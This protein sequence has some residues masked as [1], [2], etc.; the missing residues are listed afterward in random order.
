MIH[1][2]FAI[3]LFI[4]PVNTYLCFS[5]TVE[6]HVHEREQLWFG[7]FNQ[8]RI[9]NKF[10]IWFDVHYRQT[11]NFIDR[12]FQFVVR[13]GV[14]YFL[15]DNLRLQAGYAFFEHF[16]AKGKDTIR[17]EHRT[18]QQIVWNQKYTGFTTIQSLRLEERFNR[19]VED[20]VL[21]DEYNFNYRIRYSMSFLIP[22]KGKEI[23]PHS[24]YLAIMDE[25]F[26][27]FGKEIVYNTFDQNRLFAGAGYQFT[28]RL[29]AQLGYLNIYQQESSG[30][31]FLLT[32]AIRFAIFHSID[33]RSKV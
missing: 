8:T 33:L 6:K 26:V 18:W 2:R 17:P 1:Q 10:G 19:K 15:R 29:N 23:V 27:N 7:Y 32:H 3:L 4:L 22:L 30:N 31:S 25:I 11:D 28:P 14:M 5:Q 12:P 21:Q 24:V 16:P 9:T 13:P 20:D